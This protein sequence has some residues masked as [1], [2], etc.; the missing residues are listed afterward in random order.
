MRLSQL[1]FD[2]DRLQTWSSYI[3]RSQ[4]VWSARLVSYLP[5]WAG[6]EEQRVSG[7]PGLLSSSSYQLQGNQVSNNTKLCL[8]RAQGHS[9]LS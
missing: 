2:G 1:R 7:L 4:V 8:A 5:V 3:R 9:L 6:P